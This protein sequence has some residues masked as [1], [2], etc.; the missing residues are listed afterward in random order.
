MAW[1]HHVAVLLGGRGS[2]MGE[3]KHKVRLPSGETFLDVM[4]KTAQQIS[5]SVVVVGE[6]IV[7]I[8][9]LLDVREDCGPLA[10]IEALLHSELDDQY[11]IIGCDML[12][13]KPEHVC[14]LIE[15]DPS[16]CFTAQQQ[17]MGLPLKL[18][19]DLRDEC[20]TYL[21]GGGRSIHGFLG[22]VPHRTFEASTTIVK[23]ISSLNSRRDL[24]NFT[25]ENRC[26]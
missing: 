1:Q 12:L 14:T 9:S 11:L 20:S 4:M 22:G 10:G 2:R 8:P 6:E 24:D 13:L 16:A 23:A 21:D 19:A 7:G 15:T 3:P 17:R 5:S 18:Q 26:S 25:L